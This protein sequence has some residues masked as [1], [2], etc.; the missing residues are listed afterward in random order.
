MAVKHPGASAVLAEF[1]AN[2]QFE[3]LP[4]S[5]VDRLLEL[6]LDWFGSC[7]AG[8]VSRQAAVFQKLAAD[9]GPDRGAG[10]VNF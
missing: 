5:A 3:D 2:L 10:G 1:C 4:K 8:S 7:L 9:M 6:T